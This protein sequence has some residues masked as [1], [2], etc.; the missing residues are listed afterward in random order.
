MDSVHLSQG[1]LEADNFNSSVCGPSCRLSIHPQS[2]PGCRA[3]LR[4]LLWATPCK[5]GRT[6]HTSSI[7]AVFIPP[8]SVHI[9]ARSR[10]AEMVCLS[11]VTTQ[12]VRHD[13]LT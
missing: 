12:R 11:A 4:H 6:H 3:H 13:F 10:S 5:S 8:L 2:T 7:P 1:V 9:A